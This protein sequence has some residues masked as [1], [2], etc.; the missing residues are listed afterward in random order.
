[1]DA[2]RKSI[3]DVLD[4]T[5]YGTPERKLATE[6]YFTVRKSIEAQAPGYGKVLTKYHEATNH[7]KD[8]ERSLS[9]GKSAATETSLRKLQAVM[10][11]DVSSAYGKRAEYA[12]ELA[13]SGAGNLEPMLAGQ[14]LESWMPRGLRSVVATAGAGA[15]GALSPQL[16]PLLLAASPRLMG[17][18]A[19]GTGKAGR[20]LDSRLAQMLKPSHASLSRLAGPEEWRNSCVS[21]AQGAIFESDV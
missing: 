3:G 2:F 17:K 16:L 18:A 15:T 7:L 5:K 6:V 14:A 21:T 13:E 11:D 20:M 19:R 4:S 1:M 10:R 9:L 8:L 12:S